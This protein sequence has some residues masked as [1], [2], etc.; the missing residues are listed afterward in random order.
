MFT[1]GK[2]NGVGDS[3]DGMELDG[4]W[5]VVDVGGCGVGEELIVGCLEV[6][7]WDGVKRVRCARMGGSIVDSPRPADSSGSFQFSIFESRSY[8][9]VSNPARIPHDTGNLVYYLVN[10]LYNSCVH[11]CMHLFTIFI[12]NKNHDP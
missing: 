9:R 4:T 6:R 8:F 2:V 7:G 1:A 10:Q 3:S 12:Q 11:S 5:G